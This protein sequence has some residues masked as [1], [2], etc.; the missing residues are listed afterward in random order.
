[1]LDFNLGRFKQLPVQPGVIWQGGVFRVPAWVMDD[2]DQ[3]RRPW[4]AL[5]ANPSEPRVSQPLFIEDE[6]PA[7]AAVKA[8]IDFAVEG[9][10]RA[11]RPFAIEVLDSELAAEIEQRL[12]GTK[13]RVDRVKE[14]PGIRALIDDMAGHMNKRQEPPGALSA[15]GVGIEQ[16][17]VF[18]EAAVRFHCARLWEELSDDDL[19]EFAQPAPPPGMRFASVLGHGGETFGLGFFDSLKD[20]EKMRA[21]STPGR[22]FSKNGA[23]SLM[24][25][26]ITEL[27]FADADLWEDHDL[28]VSGP[29]GYPCALWFGPKRQLRRPGTRE[30]E[31]LNG[32]LHALAETTS[33][34]LDAGRWSQVVAVGGSEI[35]YRLA[36]VNEVNET[37]VTPGDY[38][39]LRRVMEKRSEERRVGKE[40]RSRWSPYH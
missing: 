20:Y 26:N 6:D 29:D 13:V 35:E 28:P 27:P 32:L 36:L 9:G 31:F 25:G 19:I 30:L 38:H 16:M 39:Q 40:C 18:A 7:E 1:M 23:W 5:W 37:A 11:H 4:M 21:A 22:F 12:Q 24:F 2:G 17:R 33:E 15:K 14:L 3:P 10:R 8:L 34:D